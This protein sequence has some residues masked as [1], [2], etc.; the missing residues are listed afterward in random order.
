M[1]K[2]EIND[3][4]VWKTAN[5][6]A[7]GRVV[8]Y[9]TLGFGYMIVALPNSRRMLVNECSATACNDATTGNYHC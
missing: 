5:G 3:K 4:V 6:M 1:R 9:D 2:F 7:S 8:C